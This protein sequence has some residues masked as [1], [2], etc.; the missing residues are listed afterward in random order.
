MLRDTVEVD[1]WEL[2]IGRAIVASF[3][4]LFHLMSWLSC[5]VFIDDQVGVGVSVFLDL[6]LPFPSLT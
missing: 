2:A 5:D 3:P 4:T 6:P 1:R